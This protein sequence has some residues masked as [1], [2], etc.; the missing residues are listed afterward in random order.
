MQKASFNEPI[1]GK[2]KTK[3]RTN[4]TNHE[5]QIRHIRN[6]QGPGEQAQEHGR[7]VDEKQTNPQRVS[8]QHR[9]KYKLYLRG[10]EVQ[11]HRHWE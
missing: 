1:Q 3:L 6:T 9:L 7:G 11:V 4:Q 2:S 8:E 5:E 10:D